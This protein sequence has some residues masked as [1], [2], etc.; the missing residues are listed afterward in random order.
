IIVG[1][2]VERVRVAFL[3]LV[4]VGAVGVELAV[5]IG[6]YPEMVERERHGPLGAPF[7]HD[8]RRIHARHNGIAGRPPA[9]VDRGWIVDSPGA[10]GFLAAMAL[11]IYGLA[12]HR[13]RCREIAV[14]RCDALDVA[15]HRRVYGTVDIEIEAQIEPML[16]ID[17][18][19]ARMNRRS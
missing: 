2:V 15:L 4:G 1:V 6:R 17:A 12:E 8:R 10:R 19:R 13:V 9:A 14:A 3:S 5:S 11:G 18:D 7:R 16:M